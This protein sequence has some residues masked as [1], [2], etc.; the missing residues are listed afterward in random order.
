MIPLRERR[1]DIELFCQKF[2]TDF[3]IR[4]KKAPIQPDKNVLNL[5]NKYPWPGN[6]RELQNVLERA[7]NVCSEPI[8]SVDHLPVEICNARAA[9]GQMPIKDY[10]RELIISLLEK[11]NRNI[12]RVANELG[13]ARTTL[14]HKIAKYNI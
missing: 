7:V 13:V 8:L 4:F 1:G 10:E 5:F 3:C 6:I 12:T 11:H 2:L 9:V 14:Y